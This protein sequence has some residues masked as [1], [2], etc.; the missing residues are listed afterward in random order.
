LQPSSSSLPYFIN[1][2]NDEDD[3]DDDDDD[4]VVFSLVVV[5]FS[6]GVGG[7]IPYG[8]IQLSGMSSLLSDMAIF[9][10]VDSRGE[11]GGKARADAGQTKSSR[12]R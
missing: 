9:A 12:G 11:A 2:I 8:F 5:V 7:S 10:R 6:G 4:E 1:L 3:D